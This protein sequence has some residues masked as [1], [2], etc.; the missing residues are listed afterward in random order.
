MEERK[1]LNAEPGRAGEGSNKFRQ[2]LVRRAE[3]RRGTGGE[4]QWHEERGAL[5]VR[6]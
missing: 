4:R 3:R 2:D 6:S 5:T 1:E